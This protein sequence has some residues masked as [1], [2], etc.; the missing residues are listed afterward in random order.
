MTNTTTHPLLL[1]RAADIAGLLSTEDAVDSQR[2]AF[3][4]LSSG[5]GRLAAR[6]LI[7]GPSS[8]TAFCYAARLSDETGPV[9]KFGSVNPGNRELGL[10]NVSALVLALDPD[11]GRPVAIVDGEAVTTLRT[12]AASAV[13]ARALSVPGS[14]TLTILGCGVQGRAH[15]RVLSTTLGIT[16][17]RL[18][19]P[20]AEECRDVAA[21]LGE[22][23]PMEVRAF[24]SAQE[25]VEHADIVVTATTSEAPILPTAA[26][27][28]GTTVISVGS[29]APQRKEVDSDFLSSC[30]AVFVD[31][32]P[33]AIE[34]AGPII[35]GLA[36]GVIGMSDVAELGDVLTGRHPGRVSDDSILFYNS[37]GIGLQDAAVTWQII[38][39]ARHLGLGT[40]LPM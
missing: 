28:P 39:K 40:P 25:A 2:A 23:L 35:E 27:S 34:Q 21:Q 38:E 24:T 15:A 8:S 26:V 16:E 37:V 4:A 7:N 12:A 20:F 18:W 14:K 10:P 31:H 32:L 6:L 33:T 13:A 11:T 3:E 29:F 30:S 9:C 19:S 36:Q 17:V 5:S 1:L 22:E